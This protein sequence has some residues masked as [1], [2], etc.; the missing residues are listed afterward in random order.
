MAEAVARNASAIPAG[1][2][3]ALPATVLVPSSSCP[4]PPPDAAVTV[5]V[6]A[7]EVATLPAASRA[8]AAS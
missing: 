6:T 2:E 1:T 3:S 5:T 7:A 8:R 4:V